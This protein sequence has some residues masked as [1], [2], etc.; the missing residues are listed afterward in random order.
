MSMSHRLN[1]VRVQ[2]KREFRSTLNGLGIYVMLTLVFLGISYL[3]FRGTLVEVIDAGIINILHP[4]QEPFYYAVGLAAAYLGLCAAISI[5]RERDMGTIEVLFYGPVDS[6]SYVMGKYVQ[7][8]M[9]FGVVLIFSL[10]NFAIVTWATN[11]GMSQVLGL[12]ILSIFLT[13]AVV[14]FGILLSSLTRKMTV[15]VILFLAL[16][17][18]FLGFNVVHSY[19]QFLSASG[20]QLAPIFVYVRSVFDNAS[21]VIGWISPL[22]YFD[23]GSLALF[24][25]DTGGYL[26][27]LASSLVYTVIALGLSVVVFNRKGVRR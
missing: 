16:I 12:V 11:L 7:Q 8:M 10:I 2:A 26:L 9:A 19:L 13:S 25:G 4:G 27:S 1:S 6:T 21:P 18:F 5:S 20:T 24:M 14:S 22:A 23:R 15:S 17:L 3:Y